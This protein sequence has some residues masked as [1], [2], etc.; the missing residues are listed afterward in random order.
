MIGCLAGR[1]AGCSR[2]KET[3]IQEPVCPVVLSPSGAGHH[4]HCEMPDDDKLTSA[5][6]M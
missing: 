5:K 6:I 4:G 2:H 3:G 1:G